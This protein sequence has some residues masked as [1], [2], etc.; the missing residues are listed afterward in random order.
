MNNTNNCKDKKDN[1]KKKS[2]RCKFK[3]NGKTC[4]KKLKLTAFSCRC[5]YIYC[6]KHRLPEQHNCS[7]NYKEVNKE[8]LLK[9]LGGGQYSKI[10]V[11]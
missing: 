10:E 4:N 9:N 5:G 6:S 7:I 2:I 1:K 8:S 11:I 3:I